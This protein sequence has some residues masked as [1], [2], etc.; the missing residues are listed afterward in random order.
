[1]GYLSNHIN[2]KIVNFF[3]F[4]SYYT[5]LKQM[6]GKDIKLIPHVTQTT[7]DWGTIPHHIGI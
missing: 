6:N 2:F 3:Y 1:M 4:V 7:L 5:I